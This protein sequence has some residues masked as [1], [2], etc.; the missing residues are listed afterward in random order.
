MNLTW[1]TIPH[2]L[3]HSLTHTLSHT[4]PHFITTTTKHTHHSHIHPDLNP[5]PGRPKLNIIHNKA[6]RMANPP[7]TK[8][9]A[10][11]AFASPVKTTASSSKRARTYY[12]YYD[13][14]EVDSS[15]KELWS[16]GD[17]DS[18]SR[19]SLDND[20]WLALEES[21]NPKYRKNAP[22]TEVRNSIQ[23]IVQVRGNFE[24]Q[25]FIVVVALHQYTY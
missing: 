6:Y 7:G 5:P 20:D 21:V 8:R 11:T 13:D 16:D 10:E 18:E 2:S 3:T 4:S 17:M 15:P 9:P 1:A 22:I 25:H 14:D 19:M 12:N 23:R 24:A